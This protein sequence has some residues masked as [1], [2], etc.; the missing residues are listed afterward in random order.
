MSL[1]NLFKKVSKPAWHVIKEFMKK[2]QEL[3]F[4]SS[5]AV[6]V[7]KTVNEKT[8]ESDLTES[9]KKKTDVHTL[10]FY[11]NLALIFDLNVILGVENQKWHFLVKSTWK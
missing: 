11:K 3:D 8:S 4:V 2:L 5:K 7:K 10:I 1:S 6:D 9:A